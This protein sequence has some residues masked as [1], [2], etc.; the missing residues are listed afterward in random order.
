ML[1]TN[2]TAHFPVVAMLVFIKLRLLSQYRENALCTCYTQLDK[3]KRPD[4]D[5]GWEANDA[6]QAH[7]GHQVTD[8]ELAVRHKEERVQKSRG[9][10]NS[11]EERRQVARLDVAVLNKEVSVESGTLCKLP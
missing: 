9:K 11:Q 5:R 8:G 3:V 10:G 6:H 2:L 1:E 7:I 4:G